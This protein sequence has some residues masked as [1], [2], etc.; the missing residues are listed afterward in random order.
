MF[1]THCCLEPMVQCVTVYMGPGHTGGMRGFE[2]TCTSYPVA[3]FYSSAA[4]LCE[5]QGYVSYALYRISRDISPTFLHFK[6]KEGDATCN[7]WERLPTYVNI[8][9]QYG[10]VCS[11]YPDCCRCFSRDIQCFL[12]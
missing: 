3:V 11:M 8:L 1:W 6:R 2:V 9:T 12:P 10:W 7:N 4:K 5:R